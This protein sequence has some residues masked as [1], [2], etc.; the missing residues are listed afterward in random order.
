[1]RLVVSA[2]APLDKLFQ[3]T[4]DVEDGL[5]LSDSQRV[6]MDDLE[7]GEQ[8]DT[9]RASVFSGE[10]EAFAY[11]RTVSRLYEMQKSLYWSARKPTSHSF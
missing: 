3:L 6:L 4:V 2:D 9:A 7:V 1:V 5:E 11:D 8:T 10:D